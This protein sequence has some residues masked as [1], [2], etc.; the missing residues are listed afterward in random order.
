[1]NPK[2]LFLR[3]SAALILL[4]FLSLS[5]LAQ[6]DTSIEAQDIAQMEEARRAWEKEK[7]DQNKMFDEKEIRLE[8]IKQALL[9][10]IDQFGKDR[11]DWNQEK[12][13]QSQALEQ[14]AK[15]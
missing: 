11:E 13:M 14:R 4:S 9:A 2:N 15:E 12:K 7:A 3:L 10:K 5:A 1:M 8:Q 6:T